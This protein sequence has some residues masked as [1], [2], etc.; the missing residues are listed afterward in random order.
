MKKTIIIATAMLALAG[1]NSTAN[2]EQSSETADNKKTC[3]E[4]K[5]VGSRIAKKVCKKSG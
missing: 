4:V 2:P 1:C 3:T 5:S